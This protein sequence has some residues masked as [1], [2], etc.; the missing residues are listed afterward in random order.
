M[1]SITAQVELTIHRNVDE[2]YEESRTHVYDRG[3][4]AVWNATFEQIESK[5][6]CA[7]HSLCYVCA[8]EIE[9][10]R[11]LNLLQI[12]SGVALMLQ[13]RCTAGTDSTA[14]TGDAQRLKKGANKTYHSHNILQYYFFNLVLSYV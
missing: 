4:E 8:P 6:N 11:R 2:V 7:Q 13:V 5:N 12:R 3:M 14:P 9:K 1:L 10:P